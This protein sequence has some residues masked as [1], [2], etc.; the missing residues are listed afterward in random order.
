[1]KDV[2][3][4]LQRDSRS[5]FVTVTGACDTHG[6]VE[7]DCDVPETRNETRQRGSERKGGGL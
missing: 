6:E 5:P 3:S 4:G 1:M 7:R 2:K